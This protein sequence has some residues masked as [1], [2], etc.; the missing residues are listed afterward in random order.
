M[1]KATEIMTRDELRAEAKELKIPGRGSM[2]AAQLRV[3]VDY[4][5]VETIRQETVNEVKR[6]VEETSSVERVTV[7]SHSAP[8][9]VT[10]YVPSRFRDRVAR[11]E[12]VV[13]TPAGVGG[14]RSITR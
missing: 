8:F 5:R 7:H 3:A 11:G 4:Y 14:L 6:A 1:L 10:R 12:L 13:R 2:T 9:T